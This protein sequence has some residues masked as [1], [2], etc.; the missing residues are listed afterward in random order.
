MAYAKPDIWTTTC[1]HCGRNVDI[2][3]VNT[4][5]IERQE[6]EGLDQDDNFQERFWSDIRFEQMRNPEGE[7]CDIE[8]ED[9]VRIYCLF[10]FKIHLKYEH[11]GA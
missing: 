1:H 7:V 4:K 6:K 9:H 10:C 5:E 8:P 11:G 3:T 2:P